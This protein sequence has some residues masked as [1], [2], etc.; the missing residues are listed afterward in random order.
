M[1]RYREEYRYDGVGNF[2]AMLHRAEDGNW[3]RAYAYNEPSLLEPTKPNNR[4]SSITVGRH[5]PTT[6]SYTHDAHGNITSMPHLRLMQWDFRDQLSVTARQSVTDGAPETT[7]YVYDASGIRVRK[8]TERRNAARKSECLYLGG[9]ETYRKYDSSG[10]AILER[11]SLHV[12]DG[13]RRI[14]MVETRVHGVDASPARLIRF[15]VSNH[16]DSPALE[17]DSVGQLISYEE[18]YPYGATSYQQRVVGTPKRYRYTGVERDEESGLGYHATRYYAA[19]LGRWIACDPIGIAAGANLFLYCRSNPIR[20]ADPGGTNPP[21]L[22]DQA[23]VVTKTDG[24]PNQPEPP[25]R[26]SMVRGMPVAVSR[27]C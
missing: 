9:F 7:Y 26:W 10:V 25:C 27:T 1:R 11:D 22:E 20:F 3:T 6:M 23:K 24:V 2:L 4:L 16:L 21:S 8:V 15:Q 17:L 19:W 12:L 18:Y 13:A 14:A 5:D